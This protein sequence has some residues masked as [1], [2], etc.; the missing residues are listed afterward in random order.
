[1]V[2][3]KSSKTLEY[4]LSGPSYESDRKRSTETTQQIHKDFEDLFN[5]IGCFDSTFSL[6]L[7]LD[8]KPYQVPPRCMA[9]AL[10][11]P[12]KGDL[13]GLQKQDIIAP[14]GVDETSEW[15]NSFVLVP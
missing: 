2:E 8:S 4:F 9:Y 14:P 15:C 3:S 1:M 11:K 12:F 7:K 13:E 10:Q 6:Q 5:H